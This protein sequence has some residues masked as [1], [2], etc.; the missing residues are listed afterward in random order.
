MIVGVV[1]FVTNVVVGLMSVGMVGFV[2]DVMVVVVVVVVVGV[3][4]VRAGSVAAWV[5]GA[6][7]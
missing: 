4:V 7:V 6:V 3:A 1:G 2:T 5:R